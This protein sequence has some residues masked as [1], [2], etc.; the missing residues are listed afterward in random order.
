MLASALGVSS[1]T[2]RRRLD[3]EKSSIR[4]IK[5]Q[6]RMEL[7]LDYLDH[8]RL[9]IDDL[10]AYLDISSSKAFARAFKS[11]KGITPAQYRDRAR[12]SA[13]CA[14]QRPLN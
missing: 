13:E 7:A 3:D 14:D 4:R 9:N 11:Q 2:L 6:A 12:Q 5:E 1:A 10:A 8:S